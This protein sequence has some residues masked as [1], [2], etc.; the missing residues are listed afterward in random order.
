MY[1]HEYTNDILI[2]SSI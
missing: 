1:K 2:D